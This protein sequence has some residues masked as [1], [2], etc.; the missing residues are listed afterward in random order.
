MLIGLG[1]GCIGG[2]AGIGGS[3]VMLPGLSLVFA[4]SDPSTHHVFM[5]A[6][7]VV[8]M[9]VAIPAARKHK[10]A[11]AVRME[12]V[13]RMLGP[14]A[15]S[16]VVGVLVSNLLDGRLLRLGLACF[17][18]LYCLLS[19]AALARRKPDHTGDRERTNPTT[20]VAIAVVAGLLGG[21]LGIGGGVVMVPA[22]QLLCRV[23]LRQAIGTSAGVMWLTAL[24]GAGLKLAT[25]NTHGH[26]PTHALLLALFM[27]PGAIIGARIGAGLAHGLPIATVRAIIATILTIAAARMAGLW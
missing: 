8:N 7:M 10:A 2:I 24:I 20:I 27:T 6:A 9:A 15:A 5:A 21:L 11:G 14:M 17:I 3:M 4:N 1:A 26:E 13:R 12:I 22:L 23:P 16:I 18:G 25:L 19:F